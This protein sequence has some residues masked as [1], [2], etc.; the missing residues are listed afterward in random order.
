MTIITQDITV[1]DGQSTDTINNALLGNTPLM[2]YK[3]SPWDIEKLEQY[4]E[5]NLPEEINDTDG[6]S[7]AEDGPQI[8]PR[9]EIIPVDRGQTK[10]VRVGTSLF[11]KDIN[12]MKEDINGKV[13]WVYQVKLP[14]VEKL[15]KPI[16]RKDGEYYRYRI[17]DARHRF[18]ATMEYKDF[19][20]YIVEG[21]E[22]DIE[23]LAQ[24]L[25]NPSSFEKKRDNT[26]SDVMATIQEQMEW[27]EK[28]KGKKG[29]GRDVKSIMNY[30]K[31]HFP[32]T[33]KNDRKT[34]ADRC[35]SAV[36]I[37]KDLEDLTKA[38]IANLLKEHIPDYTNSGEKD[39]KGRVGHA[40]RVGR[41]QEQFNAYIDMAQ[42]QIDYYNKG[43]DIPKHYFIASFTMGAGVSNE[44]TTENLD[45]KRADAQG[46]W[47]KEFVIGICLPIAKMYEEDVLVEPST[48]FIAQNNGKGESPDKLY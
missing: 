15:K 34:F 1:L 9:D 47:M 11:Y 3:T 23:L 5:L 44:P 24:K 4:A 21:H 2:T 8:I 28:T 12:N 35:L 45:K 20:C 48:R 32:Q 30:L 16:K 7:F 33:A 14:V 6:I 27:F 17:V 46:L 26:E 41:K 40:L 38:Q 36:G 42:T 10:Q 37:L 43:V 18:M 25:N 22:A 31:R 19:P 29:C 13:G 39:N